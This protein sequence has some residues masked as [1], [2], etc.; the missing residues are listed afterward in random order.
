MVNNL[1][2]VDYALVDVDQSKLTA[3]QAKINQWI[4][5]GELVKVQ[6]TVVQGVKPQIL[7]EICRKKGE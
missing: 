6:T 1:Y 3:I 5:K 2:R 7:F 4:T